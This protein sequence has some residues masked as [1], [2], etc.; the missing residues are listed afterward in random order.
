MD[1][2]ATS[3]ISEVQ[4]GPEDSEPLIDVRTDPRAQWLK[5]Q[6]LNFIGMDDEELFYNMLQPT[7]AKEKITTF[8]AV[9]LKPNE[10]SLDK[11]TFYVA[12][13]I[14]DKLIH[15]DKEFM[16]WSKYFT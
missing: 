1:P 7:E 14:V 3:D 2:D 10:L 8:L 5:K 15:E 4:S 11:R 12:K 16:E 9:P 13:I 6:I